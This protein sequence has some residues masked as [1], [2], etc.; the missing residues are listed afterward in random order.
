MIPQGWTYLTSGTNLAKPEWNEGKW[1]E[2][3]DG[4]EFTINAGGLNV[5]T[6][7][8]RHEVIEEI[9]TDPIKSFSRIDSW[10]SG[11]V[12]EEFTQRNRTAEIRVLFPVEDLDSLSV[13]HEG[14]FVLPSGKL[15]KLAQFE[16]GET[17]ILYF[18]PELLLNAFRIRTNSAQADQAM[19]INRR[20]L[21]ERLFFGLFGLVAVKEISAQDLSRNQKPSR[22]TFERILKKK[23]I[24]FKWVPNAR[25][26]EQS[27][28]ADGA[29]KYT[30]GR[31]MPVYSTNGNVL[32]ANI[33]MLDR[34]NEQANLNVI[35][36]ETIHGLQVKREDLVNRLDQLH[37]RIV[38]TGDIELRRNFYQLISYLRFHYTNVGRV[39][40]LFA[41]GKIT[42]EE[43][44][45]ELSNWIEPGNTV[46]N[47]LTRAGFKSVHVED[48]EDKID[49]ELNNDSRQTKWTYIERKVE[50]KNNNAK[51]V[52][53]GNIFFKGISLKTSLPGRT[54]GQFMAIMDKPSGEITSG[55][56]RYVE[57][58]ILGRMPNSWPNVAEE[59][60]A[61]VYDSFFLPKE[62]ADIQ[63]LWPFHRIV[64]YPLIFHFR[65]KAVQAKP[66]REFFHD[67]YRALDS[68]LPI[69]SSFM[70]RAMKVVDQAMMG[71]ISDFFKGLG[72]VVAGKLRTKSDV[73][74]QPTPIEPVLMNPVQEYLR[75]IEEIRKGS[76]KEYLRQTVETMGLGLEG[77]GTGAHGLDVARQILKSGNLIHNK[78]SNYYAWVDRLGL[79]YGPYDKGTGL[80]IVDQNFKPD[81]IW[82]GNKVPLRFIKYIVF[83]QTNAEIMRSN[84]EFDEYHSKIFS[85]R[86]LA[87]KLKRDSASLAK[88]GGIDLTP[89]NMNLQMQNA[90][91]G[92]NFHMN[93]AMLKQLQNAPGF[94]PVII[95]IQPMVNIQTF[96]GISD[97]NVDFKKG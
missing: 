76:D 84:P 89:A 47:E 31:T 27:T 60:F 48:A 93:P 18:V 61:Y 52:L 66:L 58:N 69:P 34:H 5:L 41:A 39:W 30:L 4:D 14:H 40:E 28:L 29:T 95:N 54:F 56:R 85:Y 96:L 90:G 51:I 8:Q 55:D 46:E 57:Q 63:K 75:K 7:E 21:G 12:P 65:N 2:F 6:P 16:E 68:D 50:E 70:N 79:S 74:N 23:G 73:S 25:E 72:S 42:G 44:K 38:E 17:D 33:V 82:H 87:D 11:I 15:I 9:G 88:K 81:E 83:S 45:K 64:L 22:Q 91:E 62:E 80:F 53:A 92:I 36:H 94:V 20:K 86:E 13:K 24:D 1:K 37:K 49:F 71:K 43:A 26:W 10:D 67:H 59:F 32:G 97:T 77:H 3:L 35:A 19:Q 78:G